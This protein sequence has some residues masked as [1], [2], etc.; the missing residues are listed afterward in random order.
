MGEIR[1]FPVELQ[2]RLVGWIAARSYGE[3][4]D[5]DGTGGE[6][7]WGLNREALESMIRCIDDYEPR[8]DGEDA[9]LDEARTSKGERHG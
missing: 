8:E 3:A 9:T 4:L 1:A 7:M 6:V 5:L 2:G